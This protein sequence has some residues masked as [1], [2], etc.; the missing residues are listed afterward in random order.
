MDSACETEKKRSK[1]M[2]LIPDTPR[3]Y[4]H[5]HKT[6]QDEHADVEQAR[7]APKINAT[8]LDS[9]RHKHQKSNKITSAH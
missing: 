3:N 5:S 2:R 6:V 7:K 4:I 1:W 9:R 8:H